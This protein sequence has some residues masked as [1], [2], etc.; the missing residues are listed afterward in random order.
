[1][2]SS[3]PLLRGLR[4]VRIVQHAVVRHWQEH[5]GPR[6]VALCQLRRQAPPPH[7][8]GPTSDVPQR[9]AEGFLL[10]GRSVRMQA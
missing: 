4:H 2:A 6:G 10:R 7:R 3:A 9:F 8:H 1:M 5:P